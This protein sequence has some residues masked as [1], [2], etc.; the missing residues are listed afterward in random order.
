[1]ELSLHDS[2]RVGDTNIALM[3]AQ[4]CEFEKAFHKC[5]I[6][7]LCVVSIHIFYDVIVVKCLNENY[8]L[9]KQYLYISCFYPV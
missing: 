8:V 2:F 1:M 7:Y 9:V 3:L 5:I 4:N 6:T